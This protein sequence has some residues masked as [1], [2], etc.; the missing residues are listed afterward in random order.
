L[1]K[2]VATRPKIETT[3]QAKEERANPEAGKLEAR[4]QKEAKTR[5][6]SCPRHFSSLEDVRGKGREKVRSRKVEWRGWKDR[7]GGE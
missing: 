2:P 5:I 4:S 3:L 7:E 1:Q 6:F